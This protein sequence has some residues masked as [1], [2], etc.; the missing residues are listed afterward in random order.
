MK[1]SPLPICSMVAIAAVLGSHPA[2][3]QSMNYGA[4]QDLFGEPVTTAAT[5]TPQRASEAPAN[6]TIITADDIRRS[7][8]RNIPEVLS[9]IPGL[10]VLRSGLSAYDIGVRGYQQPTQPRMLVLIDG[11]Q[12]FLDDYSRTDWSNLPVNIDDIRQIEVVKGASSALFG[13]NA[14]S[15]VIN[16]VTYSPTYDDDTVVNATLGTQHQ[17]TVDA[18]ATL[19]GA[20]GGVKLSVGGLDAHEFRTPRPSFDGNITPE[21][22]DG[23]EP[24]THRYASASAVLAVADNLQANAELTYTR[25]VSNFADNTDFNI[26]G[27]QHDKSYSA[28]AGLN[29]D[30]QLGAISANGYLNH[31]FVS[32][33]E[34]GAGEIGF[35]TKMN[36]FVGQVQDQ[37]KI[38]SSHTIRIGAEYRYRD[39]RQYNNETIIQHPHLVQNFVSLSGTWLWQVSDKASLS[40]AIRFDHQTMRQA[41]EINTTGIFDYED[42]RHTNDAISVNSNLVYNLTNRDRFRFS[43]GRGVMLPSLIQNGY[44]QIVDFGYPLLADVEGNP[45]LKPT[46]V[47]DLSVDY[48]RRIQ[49]LFSTVKTSLFY[50]WSRD[51]TAPFLNGENVFVDG[52]PAFSNYAQNVGASHGWGGEVQLKGD[53][54]SGVRWDASYSYVRVTDE[55]AVRTNIN[56]QGST[57]RHHLRFLLGYSTGPWELDGSAQYVTGTDM[58]RN[59]FQSTT[60]VHTGGYASLSG[61]LGYRFAKR[62]VVALSGT[63]LS[64]KTT[65]VSAFPAVERQVFVSLTGKF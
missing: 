30:S 28:R 33:F 57:P 11:R 64:Q 65:Q 62:Y 42:Y 26:M 15:G 17:R 27:V 7:G 24:P 20:W 45:L 1:K 37:F 61:R 6:M 44:S 4:L 43:Y 59:G 38:G 14:A 55:S 63:N 16:I 21:S 58:V 47:Q 36:L 13:S 56:Y 8:S 46:I 48:S 34:N 52:Q 23:T 25:S 31:T 40:N 9:R 19:K 53:H 35:G 12:V 39:Y 54:P 60:P 18:T 51:I 41:G 22:P 10:D 5:G 3:A 2:R 29:W 49:P 32:I 50:E